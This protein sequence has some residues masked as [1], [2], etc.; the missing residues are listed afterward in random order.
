M[1]VA[2][3]GFFGGDALTVVLEHTGS[4]ADGS[5]GENTDGVNR[6]R[7]NNQRHVLI[8]HGTSV[9]WSGKSY[10]KSTF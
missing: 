10:R 8:S 1:I 6:R 4:L 2:A 7:T 9:L 5:R 3:V